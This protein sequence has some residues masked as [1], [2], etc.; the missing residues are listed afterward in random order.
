M[1][2]EE[3][4]TKR[5]PE[6]VTMTVAERDALVRER[7][8]AKRS[9]RA[10]ADR[11][12]RNGHGKEE[13]V[14]E[15]EPELVDTDDLTPVTGDKDVDKSIFEDPDKWLAAIAKGP[16]AI[17]TLLKSEGLVTAAEAAQI[18]AKVARRTVDVERTKI[19]TDNRLMTAFPELADNQSELFK[20]TAHEYEEL[21]KFDPDAKRYPSTLF[22]AARA[23]KMK[24]AATRRPEEDEYDYDRVESERRARVSAQ[25]GSRGGRPQRAPDDN[26]ETLGPQARE[27]IEKM[28]VKEDAFRAHAKANGI[29]LRRPR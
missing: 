27:V 3:R 26:E 10:W 15:P 5:E 29:R 17:K 11:A 14:V 28:G 22:A 2:D 21:L 1:P 9:E 8:E 6:T 18:A 20:A 12:L 4:D 13:E 7:D 24:L 19:T 25:D 23:A 16:A